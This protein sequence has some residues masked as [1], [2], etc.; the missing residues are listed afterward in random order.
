MA[1]WPGSSH[2][3]HIF[4]N[5]RIKGKFDS[6]ELGQGILLG[7]SAYP[8]NN[9]LLTP[10][11]RPR[12]AAEELY[13]RSHINTR[14]VVERTFG[15]WK[16]RFPILSTGIRCK[17]TRAQQIIVATAVLHNIAVQTREEVNNE[18]LNVNEEFDIGNDAQNGVL[19]NNLTQQNLLRYFGTL[20]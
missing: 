17:I 11:A 7:D 5:S 4:N 1:R 15:I 14:T 16:R 10:I 20:L 12:T 3:A 8:L 2:D 18:W 6:G 9:Y 19:L 13:N